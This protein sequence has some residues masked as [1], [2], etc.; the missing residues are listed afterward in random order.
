MPD[1]LDE[2]AQRVTPIALAARWHSPQGRIPA[3]GLTGWV[4]MLEGKRGGVGKVVVD[5]GCGLVIA[6]KFEIKTGI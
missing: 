6:F 4:V 3:K 2:K 5:A 1:L